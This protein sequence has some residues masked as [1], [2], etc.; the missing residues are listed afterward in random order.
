MSQQELNAVTVLLQRW[1][2]GDQESLAELA[3]IVQDEFRRL[4]R[5]YL[6]RERGGHQLDSMALINEAWMRLIQWDG[7]TWENRAHFF[8]VTARI[9]RHVLVDEAR[10]RARRGGNFQVSLSEV[11]NKADD[12]KT[13]WK[14]ERLI[15]LHE[16]L[17]RLGDYDLRRR[18][19]AE[20]RLFA[21]MKLDEIAAVMQMSARQ[22][23]RE[24]KAAQTWLY[25]DLTNGGDQQDA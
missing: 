19:I 11:V 9:M 24:L 7:V 6:R 4:A 3:S 12:S 15:A 17:E 5:G 2:N 22:V 23:Q 18:R 1:S 16:A 14:S 8:G 13:V 21:G 20:M 25:H 10:R